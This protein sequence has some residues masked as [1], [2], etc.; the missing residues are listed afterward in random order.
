MWQRFRSFGPI[1][2]GLLVFACLLLM[3]LL[4]LAMIGVSCL[5]LRRYTL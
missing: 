5:A 1:M 2:A 3:L 4:E